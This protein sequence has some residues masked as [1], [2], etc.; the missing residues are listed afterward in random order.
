MTKISAIASEATSAAANDWIELETAAG[1]SKK[2]QKG[3]LFGGDY[4][5]IAVQPNSTATIAVNST[6]YLALQPLNFYLD[7]DTFPATHFRIVM[8]ASASEASQTIT[9]QMAAATAATTPLHT[10]GN[11]VAINTTSPG[12]FDSGWRTF[13]DGGSGLLFGTVA[14]K[15]S[16]GTVDIL[17]NNA[18]IMFKK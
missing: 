13:D 11:D 18:M 16:N 8:R 4:H 1:T 12:T 15:G 6:T 3:N 2:I 5:A 9:G 17:I 10:G 7:R 14:L